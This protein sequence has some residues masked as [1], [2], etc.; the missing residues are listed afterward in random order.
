MLTD[1]SFDFSGWFKIVEGDLK[2]NVHISPHSRASRAQLRLRTTRAVFRL[3]EKLLAGGL[4]RCLTADAGFHDVRP[5]SP[6][7][8]VFVPVLLRVLHRAS[9]V[10]V[11]QRSEEHT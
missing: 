3:A 9:Y 6:V 7:S 1:Q 2:R 11:L 10:C 8:R 5:R 4:A